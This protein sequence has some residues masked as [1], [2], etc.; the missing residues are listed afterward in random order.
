MGEV[1]RLRQLR[2]QA[3]PRGVGHQ[4]CQQRKGNGYDFRADAFAGQDTNNGRAGLIGRR[5][6]SG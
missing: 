4:L 2:R 5:A 3:A 6:P 1:R